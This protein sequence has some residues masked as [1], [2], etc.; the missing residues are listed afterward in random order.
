MSYTMWFVIFTEYLA[1]HEYVDLFDLRAAVR[2]GRELSGQGQSRQGRV[3]S[4]LEQ[5]EGSRE[6]GV[7]RFN[8]RLYAELVFREL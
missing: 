1:V 3:G 2:V 4:T 6:K 7:G 5:A 8:E